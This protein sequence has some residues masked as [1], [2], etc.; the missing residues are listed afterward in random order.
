MSVFNVHVDS[1][2]IRNANARKRLLDPPDGVANLFA[3][4]LVQRRLQDH[5]NREPAELATKQAELATKPSLL[6]WR[7]V[8]GRDALALES[9]SEG[10]RTGW[11]P[12]DHDREARRV[13]R[14]ADP[15]CHRRVTGTLRDH[16]ETAS[17]DLTAGEWPPLLTCAYSRDRAGRDE[18]DEPGSQEVR[19]LSPF[20]STR[21]RRSQDRAWQ[22]RSSRV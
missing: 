5:A 14:H 22:S 13:A 9:M 7:V 12:V 8:A 1:G 19:G 6:H 10:A 15:P 20:A 2:F 17:S 16:P 18:L 4:E 11:R 3:Y 21:F